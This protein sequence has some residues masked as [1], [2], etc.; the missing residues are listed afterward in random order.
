MASLGGVGKISYNGLLFSGPMISSS[1][2]LENVRGEDD[3]AVI[4]TN[5]SIQI[6]ATI[7]IQECGIAQSELT[8]TTYLNMMDKIRHMLSQD[9][10]PL[11]FED[12]VFGQFRVNTSGVSGSFDMIDVNYGPR[13][14]LAS[15]TPIAS[16]KAFEVVWS[17]VAAVGQCPDEAG[18]AEGE[19]IGTT[20][21][22]EIGD[23]K[24]VV[25]AVEWTADHRGYSSR[26]TSG[27]IEIVMCPAV[28]EGFG[29]ISA[30]DYRDRLTIHMPKAFRRTRSTWALN[31]KR[32][33]INFQVTD[34]EIDSPNAYPPGV[35]DIEVT[36]EVSV[37]AASGWTKGLSTLRGHC[38]V[39]NSVPASEA[40]EKLYTIIDTR[41]TAARV[42][43]G[44]IFLTNITVK[45]S[46]FA[47]RVEFS[48]SFYKLSSSPSGF[49]KGAGMF[50]ATADTWAEWRETM[51]GPDEETNGENYTRGTT[52]TRL[53]W[54]RRSVANLSYEPDDD[55]IVTPCTLKPF[56]VTIHNQRA[57][58][59][60]N[61]LASAMRNVCPHKQKS[62]LNYR[63]R[64]SMSSSDRAIALNEMPTTPTT[65]N[66]LEESKNSEGVSA[67][68]STTADT[69][70][71]SLQNPTARSG[72]FDLTLHVS[73][74]RVGYPPEL[75]DVAKKYA[76]NVKTAFGGTASKVATAKY[77]GCLVYMQKWAV[78][79]TVTMPTNLYAT[80]LDN[81]AKQL[82]VTPDAP[83]GDQ[84]HMDD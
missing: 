82:F 17:C 33:R 75:P 58:P 64:I 60:P 36:H 77:L 39:A 4:Y 78:N 71:A 10:K 11:I 6:K 25:Y 50:T 28:T 40:W 51:F 8:G 1:V 27:F 84:A 26:T 12:K 37:G 65:L 24:Q 67:G 5:V 63:S 3:R 61:D 70:N 42:A 59:F 14:K 45:E 20:Q 2:S 9:G 80:S 44:A 66:P 46:L 48:I 23:I 52:T 56:D 13:V 62:Y 30:D 7:A 53:P 16:N 32:D 21:A 31:N 72:S 76:L 35:V 81:L 22:W 57:I 29:L 18:F 54:A 69:N 55:V 34:A 41:I 49:L 68:V 38:E 83:D 19:V 74:A 43:V 15:I 47:R 73:A 79:Y